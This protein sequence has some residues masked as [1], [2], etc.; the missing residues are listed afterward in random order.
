MPRFLSR[1]HRRV[2]LEVHRIMIGDPK[3]RKSKTQDQLQEGVDYYEECIVRYVDSVVDEGESFVVPLFLT[4]RSSYR[5]L[6][7]IKKGHGKDRV[8]NG[9]K[10]TD[11]PTVDEDSDEES[12]AEAAF[13]DEGIEDTP[14]YAGY[15]VKYRLPIE[16][17]TVKKVHRKTVYIVV[18]YQSIKQTRDIIFHD[19]EEAQEFVQL[20]EVQKQAGERRAAAKVQASLAGLKVDKKEDLTLLVE[21][22]SGWNLPAADLTSSDPYVVCFMHGFEVHRTKHIPKT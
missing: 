6:S 18:E 20:L 12:V 7:P 10:T 3:K 19:E 16:T 17:L 13:A 8:P 14:D 21:I 9:K 1:K 5:I 4:M 11:E 2:S 22:V 15:K